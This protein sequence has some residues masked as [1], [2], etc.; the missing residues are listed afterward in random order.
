[1]KVQ[2]GEE[3]DISEPVYIHAFSDE[4]KISS[5][6]AMDGEQ[7]CTCNPS[8]NESLLPVVEREEISFSTKD[9]IGRGAFGA[10]FKGEWAGTEQCSPEVPA[11]GV[12][13]GYSCF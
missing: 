8:K 7:S 4:K 2:Y 5:S 9:E 1:M 6:V 11:T 12:F 3:R 13:A 10:V